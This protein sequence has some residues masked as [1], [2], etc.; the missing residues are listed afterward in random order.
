MVVVEGNAPTLSFATGVGEDWGGGGGVGGST[1][2]RTGRPS[3][4]SL[5]GEGRD[6][7]ITTEVGSKVKKNKEE[8][9]AAG[10]AAAAAAADEEGKEPFETES[11]PTELWD[12]DGA[13]TP[14]ILPVHKNGGGC[15]GGIARRRGGAGR[16]GGIEGGKGAG[17]GV[18]KAEEDKFVW[19]KRRRVAGRGEKGGWV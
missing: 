12:S 4:S 9:D 11:A 16:V 5:G 3:L 2:G 18:M 6:R 17:G 1:G 19:N 14:S 15:S 8:G 10:V 13:E 7:G